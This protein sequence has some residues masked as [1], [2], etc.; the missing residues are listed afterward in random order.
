MES[1][2]FAPGTEY[3]ARVRSSP[4]GV[5]YGGEWSAWS[6][7]VHWRTEWTEEGESAHHSD[8]QLAAQITFNPACLYLPDTSTRPDLTS[9]YGLA[10]VVVPVCVLAPFVLL[11]S[12]YFKM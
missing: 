4:D 3:A 2:N 6:S 7:E 9:M 10:K 12:A 8:A 11:C 1:P 5:N